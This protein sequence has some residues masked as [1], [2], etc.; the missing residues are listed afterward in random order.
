MQYLFVTLVMGE[1]RSRINHAP[2]TLISQSTT[3]NDFTLYMSPPEI[4]WIM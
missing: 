4:M 3:G 2:D 1:E